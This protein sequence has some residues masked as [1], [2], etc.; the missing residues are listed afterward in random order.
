MEMLLVIRIKLRIYVFNLLKE[1]ILLIL[2]WMIMMV[3]ELVVKV[4]LCV[5]VV[6]SL[7]KWLMKFLKKFLMILLV[8]SIFYGFLV[9]EEVFMLGCVMRELKKCLKS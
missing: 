4:V 2:I 9:V 5:R 7:Y 3:L 6:G 1:S 8:L